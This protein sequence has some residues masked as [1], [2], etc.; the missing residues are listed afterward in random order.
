MR[1]LGALSVGSAVG[2]HVLTSCVTTQG[3]QIVCS[4]ATG[5]GGAFFV[6][7]LFWLA[8]IVVFILAYISIVT[9]A[10]Y[11]GWWVLTGLIPLV[12]IVMFLIFA[13]S[14]WPIRRELEALRTQTRVVGG[15]NPA[16]APPSWNPNQSAPWSRGGSYGGFQAP[17]PGPTTAPG[18]LP[19][20]VVA[21]S[22][23]APS[24]QGATDDSPLPPFRAPTKTPEAETSAPK[25]AVSPP[26]EGAAPSGLPPAGWYPTA[27]GRRRYW[28]G[29]RWTNHFS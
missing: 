3:G 2:N 18:S 8:I 4:S 26:K 16:F 7:L 1:M 25:D 20:G 21:P 17:G 11:S 27:D 12:G 15:Y 19:R 6:F 23:G 13:F 29:A 24:P 10:G 5:L 9:K 28:D 22:P 14:K